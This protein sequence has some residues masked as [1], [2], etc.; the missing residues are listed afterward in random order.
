SPMC[1]LGLLVMPCTD[2]SVICGSGWP[3]EWK[4]AVMSDGSQPPS[5]STIP[6]T[7]PPTSPWGQLYAAQ[8]AGTAQGAAATVPAACIRKY[9]FDFVAIA[10]QF[11]HTNRGAK[12]LSGSSRQKGGAA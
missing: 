8:S 2:T 12:Q 4:N 6:I 1:R 5:S 3:M 7:P 11:L 9:G 10:I